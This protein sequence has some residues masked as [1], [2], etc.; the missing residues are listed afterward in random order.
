M[1]DNPAKRFL[2]GKRI[3]KQPYEIRYVR[4]RARQLMKLCE[5]QMKSCGVRST[6]LFTKSRTS[7]ECESYSTQSIA[8]IC[9]A[10]LKFVTIKK[11][12]R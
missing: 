2:D 5:V 6:T 12:T 10:I 1:K 9:K 8:R 11:F 4:K 7:G 3:S